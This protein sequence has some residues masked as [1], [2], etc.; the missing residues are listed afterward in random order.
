MNGGE[1]VVK[2]LSWPRDTDPLLPPLLVPGHL[3]NLYENIPTRENDLEVNSNLQYLNLSLKFVIS[4][5]LCISTKETR[6]ENSFLI[7]VWF[8]GF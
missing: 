7:K 4:H 5:T 1:L 8:D 6:W 3:G 2:L